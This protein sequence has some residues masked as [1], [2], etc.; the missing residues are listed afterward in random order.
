M[1]KTCEARFSNSCAV[2]RRT[3]EVG[4]HAQRGLRL[5]LSQLFYFFRLFFCSEFPKKISAIIPKN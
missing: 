1:V 2:G 5:R 3:E 4:A